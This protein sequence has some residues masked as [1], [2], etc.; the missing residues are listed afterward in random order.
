MKIKAH[1]HRAQ[2]APQQHFGLQI[3][4]YGEIAENHDKN[5]HVVYRQGIFQDISRVKLQRMA[6]P[7]K[8]PNG[9]AEQRGQRHPGRYHQRGFFDGYMAFVLIQHGQVNK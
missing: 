4:W 7:F 1:D 9:P 8:K 3:V 6:R 2:N 5:K